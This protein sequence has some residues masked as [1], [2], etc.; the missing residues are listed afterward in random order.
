MLSPYSNHVRNID[1][2]SCSLVYFSSTGQAIASPRSDREWQTT[3]D[4]QV[5]DAGRREGFRGS[6]V[7]H[8][9]LRDAAGGV[10]M[11]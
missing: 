9:A 3:D 6:A 11:L 4:A 2:D 10:A 5:P 1:S 8:Q 7:K